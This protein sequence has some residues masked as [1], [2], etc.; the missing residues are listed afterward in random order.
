[1]NNALMHKKHDT[2]VDEEDKGTVIKIEFAVMIQ[3]QNKPKVWSSTVN[4]FLLVNTLSVFY[5][6][7]FFWT[8]VK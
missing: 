8:I 5:Q 6:D 4:M 3:M 7:S 2:G 1:M